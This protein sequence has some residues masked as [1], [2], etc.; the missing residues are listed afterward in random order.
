MGPLKVIFNCQ[1]LKTLEHLW[2]DD[3]SGYFDKM[4]EQ[5]LATDRMKEKLNLETI[6]MKT[7]KRKT[8]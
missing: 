4:A 2:S 1:S 6:S 5:Y 3:L 8:I 7:M